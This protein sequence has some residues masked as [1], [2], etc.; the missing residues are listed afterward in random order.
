MKEAKP[1]LQLQ[2]KKKKEKNVFVATG[3]STSNHR[4]SPI[5]TIL[6]KSPTQPEIQDQLKNARHDLTIARIDLHIQV[7]NLAH[8][9]AERRSLKKRRHK[10]DGP[11]LAAMKSN[12]QR[13]E[14]A[15]KTRELR[16]RLLEGEV[17]LF[18]ILLGKMGDDDDGETPA[19]DSELRAGWLRF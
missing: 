19:S 11:R 17:T 18:K 1:T 16:V 7:S 5:V 15:A 10:R 4:P 3:K 8:A 13:M 12:I 6:K 2:K 9:K 14:Q